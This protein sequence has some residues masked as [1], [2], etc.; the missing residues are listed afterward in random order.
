MTTSKTA[1]RFGHRKTPTLV[2]IIAICFALTAI[3]YGIVEM[4][5]HSFPLSSEAAASVPHGRMTNTKSQSDPRSAPLATGGSTSKVVAGERIDRID[6]AR[7]C[8]PDEG[9]NT[10]CIF[11]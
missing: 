4:A 11:E 9:I 3:G 7:E 2:N 10:E 6:S 5:E 1:N 8:V